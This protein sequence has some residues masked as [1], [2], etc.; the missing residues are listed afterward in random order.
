MRLRR[1]SRESQ[2]GRRRIAPGLLRGSGAAKAVLYS[3]GSG[4]VAELADAL[5]SGSSELTLMGVQ[6]PPRPPSSLAFWRLHMA[7]VNNGDAFEDVT[8]GKQKERRPT[9]EKGAAQAPAPAADRLRRGHHRGRGDRR[10]GHRREAERRCG[11]LPAL[12]GVGRRPPETIGLDRR[13][14]DARC[15]PNP[16]DTSRKDIQTKLDQFVA[17]SASLETKAKAAEVPKDLLD[18]NVHQFLVMAMTFRHTGLA[19]LEPSLMNALE[20]QD[21]DVAAEQISRALY[22]LT[23][24]DFLLQGGVRLQGDG[25]RQAEEPHRGH[26]P[27]LAVPE[28]SR[29]CLP[30]R[31]RSR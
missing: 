26:R 5:G 20:V 2:P 21:T 18:Q 22:Y 3:A 28:R 15:S 10:R 8:Q 4:R 12:H 25:D 7:E 29:S 30:S 27:Q 14:A 17:K 11:R 19:D 9:A 23:N 13:R 16:G 31:R 6:V 1:R 24:S